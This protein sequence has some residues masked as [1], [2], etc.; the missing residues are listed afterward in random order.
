MT[1]T[2][3]NGLNAT[4]LAC[5][6]HQRDIRAETLLRDCLARI[7]AREPAVHAWSW[8]NRDA[9]LTQA[10]LLDDGPVSGVLH[11]L[12]VGVKDIMDTCDMP[13]AYGSSLY[14]GHR[15]RLDAAS[16]ALTRAAGAIILGKTVTTEFAVFHP[17]P[18][19]NPHHP[20]HT[21]GGSSSGS[22]AAVADRMVPLAFA[23]QTG[24]SIIRPAA[25]CGVVGYKPS[26]NTLPRAGVKPLADSLD[27]IGTL[28]RS[29]ADAAL[30]AAGASGYH[31]LILN[32]DEAPVRPRVGLCQTWEWEQCEPSQQQALL[33]AARQLSRAGLAVTPLMLPQSF[34]H[35]A[36]AQMTVMLRQQFQSLSFERL[37]HWQALSANL[38]DVLERGA[39][40]SDA[41]YWSATRLIQQC[42]GQLR[43]LFRDVDLLLVPSVTGEAPEGLHHTGN[44][45]MNRIWTALHGPALTLPVG[46]GPKGLPTAVT[47]VGMEDSDIHFLKGAQTL[48]TLLEHTHHA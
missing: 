22:A 48:E 20:G 19:T 38:R 47:V 25:Y 39:Q 8:L 37:H 32:D 43:D 30:F 36:D 12:P 11:G 16:V 6:L 40:I 33:G 41:S 21:P 18:T 9:A 34:A 5:R 10:R 15:P 31:D 45:I 1:D 23:T 35:L 14:A 28:A 42:K 17:G 46:T 44:P 4:T 29:V 2:E 13:T 3:L 27:T 24:G 7:D 26:F